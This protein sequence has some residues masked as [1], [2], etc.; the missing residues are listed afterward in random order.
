[1]FSIDPYKIFS[2]TA[3]SG[4]IGAP[5]FSIDGKCRKGQGFGIL[6]YWC[7]RVLNQPV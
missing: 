2:K 3:L 1:M 5:V 7:S 4:V 6:R